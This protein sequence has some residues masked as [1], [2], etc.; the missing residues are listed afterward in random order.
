MF[1]SIVVGTDGSAPARE[2]VGMAAEMARRDGAELHVVSAYRVF[3][4]MLLVGGGEEA[5]TAAAGLEVEQRIRAD[6]E[7]MLEGL[8]KELAAEGVAVTT[9]LSSERPAPAIL[10]VAERYDADLIVVGNRGA[11]DPKVLGSVPQKVI[12]LA[13]CSVLV[14]HTWPPRRP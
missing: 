14:V 13:P 3:S 1:T 5:K 2:A 7:A 8:A 4:D 6:V 11:S 10:D 9:H 12:H